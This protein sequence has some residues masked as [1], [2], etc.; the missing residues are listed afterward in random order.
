M[1]TQHSPELDRKLA[2]RLA[3]DPEEIP[4]LEACKVGSVADSFAHLSPVHFV[5]LWPGS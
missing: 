4:L 2:L 3:A 1:M 5:S